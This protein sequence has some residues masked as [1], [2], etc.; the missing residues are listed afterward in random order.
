MDPI[1][2][3]EPMP[4]FLT[5]VGNNSAVHTNITPNEAETPNLPMLARVTVNQLRARR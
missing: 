2:E 4:E 5:G 1:I 3:L